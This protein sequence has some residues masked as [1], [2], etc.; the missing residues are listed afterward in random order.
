MS[1]ELAVGTDLVQGFVDVQQLRWFG[2]SAHTFTFDPEL[3][4]GID[5][6][7]ATGWRSANQLPAE[8]LAAIEDVVAE[9]SAHIVEW[10]SGSDLTRISGDLITTVVG[11]E[12]VAYSSGGALCAVI[13]LA[14][15][16]PVEIAQVPDLALDASLWPD[17]GDWQVSSGSMQLRPG[18]LVM[19]SGSSRWI[20]ASTSP[21]VI[22]VLRVEYVGPVGD[23]SWRLA[24]PEEPGAGW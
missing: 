12:A 5:L 21:A 8:P 9:A 11:G 2:R 22:L 19:L 18:T 7:A 13:Q 23:A 14:G 4:V 1:D 10:R 17:S 15:S 24:S 16:D 3:L 20:P 6:Q